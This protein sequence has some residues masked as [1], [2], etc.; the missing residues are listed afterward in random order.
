MCVSVSLRALMHNYTIKQVIGRCVGSSRHECVNTTILLLQQFGQ[1][2]STSNA[3][4]GV[5]SC[6]NYNLISLVFFDFCDIMIVVFALW[7]DLSVV[8]EESSHD[9]RALE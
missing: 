4:A 8:P 2:A 1:I 6:N 7:S 3:K 9:T 5:C